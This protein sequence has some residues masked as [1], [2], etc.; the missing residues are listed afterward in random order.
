M[1][2]K[3][4]KALVRVV[5]YASGE[6]PDRDLSLDAA[7]QQI[8]GWMDEVGKEIDDCETLGSDKL[9]PLQPCL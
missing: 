6:Q 2:K 4:F 7:I 3:T 1:D 5:N 8:W 9:P